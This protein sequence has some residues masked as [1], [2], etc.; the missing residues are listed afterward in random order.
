MKNH[1]ATESDLPVAL[2]SNLVVYP[3]DENEEAIQYVLNARRICLGRGPGNQIRVD[4]SAISFSHLEL[5]KNDNGDY[6]VIDRGSKN[7]L[8][9]NSETV[10]QAVLKDGDRLLIGGAVAAYFLVLPAD[11]EAVDPVV[12]AGRGGRAKSGK[13]DDLP[14][15]TSRLEAESKSQQLLIS[16]LESALEQVEARLLRFQNPSAASPPAVDQSSESKADDNQPANPQETEAD[17][18]RPVNRIANGSEAPRVNR[19][20]VTSGRN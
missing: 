10:T 17:T 16:K 8:S 3:E 9:I 13:L 20:K 1:H 15:R 12:V 6:E 4:H 11:A 19:A 18:V 2:T 14:E 7:G 5:V